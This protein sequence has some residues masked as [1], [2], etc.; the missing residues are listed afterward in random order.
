MAKSLETL[1]F[2]TS[3]THAPFRGQTQPRPLSQDACM[4]RDDNLEF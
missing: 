3:H 4:T 1:R 2:L